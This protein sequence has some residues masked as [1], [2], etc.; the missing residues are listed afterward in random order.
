[1]VSV[2]SRS[3]TSDKRMGQDFLAAEDKHWGYR[4]SNNT[5]EDSRDFMHTH[6]QIK[7]HR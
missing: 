6:N 1:M 2:K 3:T 7:K 4:Q 5:A